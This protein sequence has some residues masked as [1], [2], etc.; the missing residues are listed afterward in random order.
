VI[1]TDGV[2]S[3]IRWFQPDDEL[4]CYDELDDERW[5][6]RHIEVRA[7]DRAFVAAASLAEVLQARDSPDGWAV[8][9]YE[10]RYGVVPELAFPVVAADDEP[11]I[12]A[13]TA[14][15][16][17]RLWEHGRHARETR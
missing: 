2:V 5:S 13:V 6:V 17:E 1:D 11:P 7:R 4:W 15:E 10:R 3:Y 8:N 9:A 14:E 12:E 16:F